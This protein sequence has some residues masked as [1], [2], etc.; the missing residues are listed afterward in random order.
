MAAPSRFIQDIKRTH[1]CGVLT[2]KNVGETVV[3]FGWVQ[4]RRDHG[5][6]VFIDLRDR[7]GITQVVFEPEVSPEAHKLAGELRSEFVLGIRGKVDSRGTQIN[8]KLKTGADRGARPTELRD[9]QPR[10]DA[11]FPDRRRDRHRRGEAA[12]PP[13]PRPAPRPAAAGPH[14]APPDAPGGARLLQRQGLPRARDAVHDPFSTPGGARNFLVPS[15]L[16]PGHFYGLAGV[17]AALQAALHGG[18]AS[19][20]TS[21]S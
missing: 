9:L 8:P 20:A 16:N 11:A 13:L 7:E 19:T 15:R 3:L 18:R 21:R 5:G 2:D 12:R 10:R 1:S 6:C 14:H 17:A 4:T